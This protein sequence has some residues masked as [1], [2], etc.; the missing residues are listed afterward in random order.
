MAPE[1]LQKS[2]GHSMPCDIW[3]LG[4]VIFTMLVGKCPFEA[5]TLDDT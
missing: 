2:S 5:N 3:S 1:V 4:V